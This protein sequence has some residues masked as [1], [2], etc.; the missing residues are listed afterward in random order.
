MMTTPIAVGSRV[1]IIWPSPRDGLTGTVT[2]VNGPLLHV[3]LD[4]ERWRG[5][6]PVPIHIGEVRLIS[7][8]DGAGENGD[9]LS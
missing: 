8:R 1:R 4:G 9:G 7:A 3:R 5:M 2:A 6:E